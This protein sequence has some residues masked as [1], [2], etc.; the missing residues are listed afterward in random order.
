MT[1]RETNNEK[2]AIKKASMPETGILNSVTIMSMTSKET[3]GL[4][5]K[6]RSMMSGGTVV[7]PLAALMRYS[8]AT[9][10]AEKTPPKMTAKSLSE[11]ISKLGVT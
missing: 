1:N 9:P 11:T 2:A 6:Q 8:A 7:P 3:A 10:I 5:W 4:T